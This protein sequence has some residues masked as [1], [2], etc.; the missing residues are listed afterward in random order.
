MWKV[1]T[2]VYWSILVFLILF[3]LEITA[4]L[5]ISSSNSLLPVHNLNN[6]ATYTFYIVPVV[7]ASN[8]VIEGPSSDIVTFMFTRTGTLV[9][10]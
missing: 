5:N 3:A 2:C 6:R 7:N 4:A 9:I 10:A 8:G 1:T